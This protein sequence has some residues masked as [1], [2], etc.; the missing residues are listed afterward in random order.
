M[1][2]KSA[3]VGWAIMH[4]RWC[5]AFGVALHGGYVVLSESH[6]IRVTHVVEVEARWALLEHDGSVGHV[7]NEFPPSA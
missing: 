6:D 2:D 3:S 4:W 1:V 5:V 7:G